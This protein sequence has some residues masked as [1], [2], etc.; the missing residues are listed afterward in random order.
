VPKFQLEESSV[1]NYVLSFLL[2]VLVVLTGVTLKRSITG[3]GTDPV[4]IPPKVFAIGTDPVPIP[5]KA[6]GIGT[7][8]VPIP[9]KAM[10]IGTDP[11]PIPPKNR[12]TR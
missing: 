4:P 3:I 6:M 2:A 9:P 11:V 1:K 10:G 12:V 8:P 5:P 7:D